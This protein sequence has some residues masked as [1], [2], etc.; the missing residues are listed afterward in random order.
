MKILKYTF[1]FFFIFNLLQLSS[2][3]Q[4]EKVEKVDKTPIDS[5]S[6]YIQKMKDVSFG[7]AICLNYANKALSFT[8]TSTLNKTDF[9]NREEILDYK[10]ILFGNL[11]LRDSII[12]ISNELLKIAQVN[13]DTALIGYRYFV[14]GYYHNEKQQR[15]SAYI[16][17]KLAKDIYFMA[18]DSAK[19]GESLA[20]MAAIQ[21][22]LG[23]YAGSDKT[24]IEALKN[25]D[26]NNI[27]YLTTVYN[28]IA[29]SARNQKD[30]SEA[31]YWY[32]KAIEITTDEK[33][34]KMYLNNKANA[35]RDLKE[36]DKAIEILSDLATDTLEI[37]ELKP[38]LGS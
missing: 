38:K 11:N 12:E 25:L 4:N 2:C 30:Y 23:D 36:Y 10:V 1:L 8:K 17:F 16:Y 24:A 18:S 22:D 14:L 9:K 19:A 29:I 3:S 15:D 6:I 32:D 13:K 21:S 37:L 27:P 5:L 34:K 35:Y 31:I 7:D 20:Y 26:E 28:C 33:F